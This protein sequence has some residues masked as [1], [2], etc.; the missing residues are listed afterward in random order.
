MQQVLRVV[1]ILALAA[2]SVAPFAG[3]QPTG[4]TPAAFAL[5]DV[6]VVDVR[7]GDVLPAQTVLVRDRRIEAVGP[8]G[9]ATVPAD[10]RVVDVAGAY[11][12]PGLWDMHVHIGY[13]DALVRNVF[14]P[15]YVAYGVTGVREMSGDSV[16][17]RLRS[18]VEQGTATGP[19]LVVGGLVDA[20]FRAGGGMPFVPARTREEGA[21]AVDSLAHRGF[22][23]VKTYSFVSPEAYR[24]IQERARE[25]DM[26]VS[27]HIPIEVELEDAMSL[28][29]G[30]IEHM[31]GIEFACS[32]R[33]DELRE[34]YGA[35]LSRMASDSV[36][37]DSAMMLFGRSEWEPIAEQDAVA[38]KRLHADL[39]AAGA[40]VVPT[41]IRQQLVSRRFE[42]PI[43][44]DPRG[45][46]LAGLLN[47]EETWGF[48]PERRLPAVYEHRLEGGLAALR[49]AGVEILAGS[50]LPGGL[51]LH[52]ELGLLV[53]AGLTPLEALRS[54]TLAPARYLGL[55][56][57]HGGVEP[58]MTAE[59]A[60]LDGNPLE[61]IGNTQRIRG[62]VLNGRWL[63]RE[64]LD[65]MLARVEA[66]LQSLRQQAPGPPDK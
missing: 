21:A 64:A 17:L 6:N 62:V 16:L 45:R 61:D 22:D 40:S 46:A 12:I 19:R 41:L 53:D 31:A 28:G 52:Y 34:R 56:D 23:F 43:L 50:D 66:V 35:E 27:G 11:V 2:G 59:L 36:A 37:A 38:C 20:P 57:S 1:S 18:E 26:E 4:E 33:E 30:T 49:D 39:A 24:G 47:P 14:F 8:A 63:D 65:G 25:L 58:G 32:A 29:H 13:G 10:A 51:P 15:M 60:L 54:A 55:E 5:T 3:A 44:S 42:T 48:D 9:E 7:T